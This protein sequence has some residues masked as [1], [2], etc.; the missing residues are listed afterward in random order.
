MKELTHVILITN[1]NRTIQ[2][3]SRQ[4]LESYNR[5]NCGI[6]NGDEKSWDPG[7]D[8]IVIKAIQFGEKMPPLPIAANTWKMIFKWKFVRIQLPIIVQGVKLLKISFIFHWTTPLRSAN[9]KNHI[10]KM[11]SPLHSPDL[12]LLGFILLGDYK[13]A[14][15][16][17]YYTN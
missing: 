12:I 17:F 13:A 2:S 6:A 8:E 3:R 5:R 10:Q 7:V 16:V 11:E 4:P 1:L 15:K 14:A 9:L